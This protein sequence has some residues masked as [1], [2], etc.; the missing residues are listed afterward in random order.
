MRTVHRARLSVFFFMAL[1]S[2]LKVS[3]IQPVECI[4]VSHL[5]RAV[6]G[7]KFGRLFLP[8]NKHFSVVQK[9]CRPNKNKYK[10]ASDQVL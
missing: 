3:V 5:S 1:Y 9:V 7:E 8:S 6:R 2:I 4:I 10:P